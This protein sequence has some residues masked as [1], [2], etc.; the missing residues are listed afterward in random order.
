MPKLTIIVAASENNVIGK[1]NALIW[2]LSADLQRFKK[3]T[4]G[5]P[6]I[7]GRKTY[8]SFPKPLPNRTHVVI[9]RNLNYKTVSGVVVVHSMQDALTAVNNE[10]EAYIIGGGEIYKQGLLIANTIELTRVHE[11]FDGDTFFP[12]IDH[13]TWKE[14]FR[15]FHPSNNSQLHSF[16]YITYQRQ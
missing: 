3:L 6:I 5:K 12:E 11:E 1:N 13:N 8:E 14:T 4:T 10:A 7:M 15:S 9:T 2:H 16:S